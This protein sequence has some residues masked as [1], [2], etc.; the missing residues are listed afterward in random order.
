MS[1][2]QN[3]EIGKTQNSVRI[4]IDGK[5]QEIQFHADLLRAYIATKA[6]AAM[7]SN[8]GICEL[9]PDRYEAEIVQYSCK[10]ADALISELAKEAK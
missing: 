4:I 7:L 8:R 6:M 1:G 5:T 10:L 2:E 3:I 9:W